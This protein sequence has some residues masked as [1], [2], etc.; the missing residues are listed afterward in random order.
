MPL[1]GGLVLDIQ[2]GNN[3]YLGD[4]SHCGLVLFQPAVKRFSH[5][6]IA[7]F[8]LIL[9]RLLSRGIPLGSSL[10]LSIMTLGLWSQPWNKG[11][12]ALPDFS[13]KNLKASSLK[14]K[15]GW[16]RAFQTFFVFQVDFTFSLKWFELNAAFSRVL[17]F[18]LS[19]CSAER[20]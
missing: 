6:W 20:R 2:K 7:R 15:F 12:S 19:G 14:L 5:N 3:L 8:L 9:L 17:F 16:G 13:G 18:G 1:R 4:Y 10:P 11:Q